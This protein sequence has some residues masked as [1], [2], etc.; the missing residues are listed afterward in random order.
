M[1]QILVIGLLLF[2]GSVFAQSA[3][4]QRRPAYQGYGTPTPGPTNDVDEP[5]EA[6][7]GLKFE[8]QLEGEQSPENLPTAAEEKNTAAGQD[9]ATDFDPDVETDIEFATQPDTESPGGS[10]AESTDTESQVEILAPVIES[11]PLNSEPEAQPRV[12]TAP[13]ATLRLNDDKTLSAVI[14]PTDNS[15]QT[16]AVEATTEVVPQPAPAAPI[17]MSPA[18]WQLDIVVFR[19]GGPQSLRAERWDRNP[20]RPDIEQF[21]VISDSDATSLTEVIDRLDTS[22]AHRPLLQRTLLFDQLPDFLRTRGAAFDATKAII[23]ADLVRGHST[24]PTPASR[25]DWP[26]ILGTVKLTQGTDLSVTV[27]LLFT[28]STALPYRADDSED[29]FL[30]GGFELPADENLYQLG[31]IRLQQ[32]AFANAGKL[33]YF[34]N[35]AIGAIVNITELKPQPL[36]PI[37]PV[38][39]ENAADTPIDDEQTGSSG[40]GETTEADADFDE[41]QTFETLESD[42]ESV[43]EVEIEVENADE[44]EIGAE[45]DVDSSIN[46]S[47][48]D[49]T[50]P[51]SENSVP[52]TLDGP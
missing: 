25:F 43:S 32:S 9:T 28:Y 27:D 51:Q 10:P 2:S 13:P 42:T 41:L 45:A 34:D 48:S 30:D 44:S 31:H 26:E 39:V 40:D 46:P 24:M 20:G 14:S 50:I 12:L 19:A 38:L 52:T 4:Q 11:S 16:T 47:P 1:K 15:A 23:D 7:I 33:L 36:E 22:P 35:P 3:D 17:K 37:K 5:A 29:P 21:D 18:R 6:T 49:E 8:S